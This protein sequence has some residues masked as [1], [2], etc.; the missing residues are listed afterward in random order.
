MHLDQ[1]LDPF[2]KEFN[3]G[4]PPQKDNKGIYPVKLSPAYEISLQELP[5]RIFFS[6]II[7]PLSDEKNKEALFIYLMKA[8]FLGQ[9]TGGNV[10]GIDQSEKFLTLSLRL[11]FEV[12]YKTFRESLEDFINYLDYWREE[13]V[14]FERKLYTQPT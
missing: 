3:L 13:V 9:G 5:P 11:P 2:Y 10:I 7:M 14:L 6:S 8:N 4:A 1:I 12:N